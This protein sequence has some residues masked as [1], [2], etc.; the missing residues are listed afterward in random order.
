[1]CCWPQ[2]R[3]QKKMMAFD[4]EKQP[5]RTHHYLDYYQFFTWYFEKEENNVEKFMGGNGFFSFIP[6]ISFPFFKVG[7][8]CR[9]W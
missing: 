9:F 3:F 7:R 6:Q 8:P 2:E 1:M 5:R 4:S